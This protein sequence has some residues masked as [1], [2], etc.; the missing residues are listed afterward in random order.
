[1]LEEVTATSPKWFEYFGNNPL[2]V[3]RH[4]VLISALQSPNAFKT[5]PLVPEHVSWDFWSVTL[6][7]YIHPGTPWAGTM[8]P[9]VGT[10]AHGDHWQCNFVY[11]CPIW[12]NSTPNCIYCLQKASSW[13]WLSCQTHRTRVIWINF[14]LLRQIYNS[15][16][17]YTAVHC[18]TTNIFKL[19][20]TVLVE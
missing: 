19:T 20:L 3:Q 8:E 16:G 17:V 15:K 5:S 2:S 18:I 14:W 7:G 6:N 12:A 13:D 10:W 4:F 9:M 11:S 1:M